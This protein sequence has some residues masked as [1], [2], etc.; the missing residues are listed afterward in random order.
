MGIWYVK[1]RDM[2]DYDEADIRYS[3]KNQGGLSLNHTSIL[4]EDCCF[5]REDIPALDDDPVSDRT[6]S[7]AVFRPVNS[8]FFCARKLIWPVKYK[9][10]TVTFTCL[11]IIDYTIFCHGDITP[12]SAVSSETL[13]VF[14]R[15]ISSSQGLCLKVHLQVPPSS[16]INTN[17]YQSTNLQYFIYAFFSTSVCFRTYPYPHGALYR[18]LN[19]P[20]QGHIPRSLWPHVPSPSDLGSLR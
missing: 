19:Y 9:N 6:Q 7:G 17:A 5:T 10:P 12:L 20:A 2:A 3:C 11:K 15:L 14:Q 16:R 1:F 4:G 8:Q 13:S 18:S